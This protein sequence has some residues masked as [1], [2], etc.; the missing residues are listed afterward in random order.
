ML[1][2]LVAGHLAGTGRARALVLASR[3]GPAAPGVAVLAAG[4]AAAGAR[5][6]VAACDAADRG[7]LAG[8]LA[9]VPA[10]SPLTGVVHSAG[11]VDDAVTGSLTPD[12]ID[13]VMRPKA[14][15]AWHLHQLTADLDLDTFM[16]FSFAAATFGS[17]GQAN[18]SAANAFLEGLAAWRQAAGLP[19]SSL[20]WG[21]WA[22][23]SA[24]TGH[25]TKGHRARIASGGVVGAMTAAEGLTLMDLAAARDEALLVPAR[26]DM[27]TLRAGAQAGSLPALF[28][29]LVPQPG[30]PARR[31]AEPGRTDSEGPALRERLA[32][33]SEAEQVRLLNDLLRSEVA[34][35]LGHASPEAID[36][37]LGFLEQG[38]DSLTLLELRNRLNAATGLELSGSAVFDYP[39]PAALAA[40]LGAEF[41]ASGRLADVD[42]PWPGDDG[43]RYTAA[44]DAAPAADAH[45]DAAGSDST[46]SK[47]RSPAAQAAR[48]GARSPG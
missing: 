14:D 9:Q 36:V 41:S 30:A 7:A 45:A 24:M 5:V 20:A 17:A 10:D 13:A 48:S 12:R 2:A 8:L 39:T 15:A 4:L 29:G 34:I 32:R 28:R 47:A 33:A 35:V 19:A 21:L 26:L 44:G 43:P 25:L 46:R 42:A 40:Q 23:A 3:S 27:A 16:L 38:F 31:I 11:V 1:G 37:E 6:Q 22:D 18:Y